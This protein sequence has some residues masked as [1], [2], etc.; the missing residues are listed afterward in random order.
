MTVF[1]PARRAHYVARWIDPETGRRK[2]H[3]LG[4]RIKREA[5]Q[6]AA[7]L[8]DKILA[9]VSPDDMAWMAFA[10]VYEAAHIAH[11]SKSHQQSW[12]AVRDSVEDLMRAPLL[13]TITAPR[14]V[15]WQERIREGRSPNTVA[16]YSTRLR[17]ALNWAR[18]RD[19]LMRTPFV[20]VRFEETPRSRGVTD[21]E[22]A[23]ILQSVPAVRP[24]DAAAWD[25]LLRGLGMTNLRISE[26]ARLSWD[27]DASIRIEQVDG[28]PMIRLAPAAH[29][30]RKPRLQVVLPEFW[31]VCRET[32]PGDRLGL[33]FPLSNGRGG[34]MT[35]KR[36]IRV[37]GSIGRAAGIVTNDAGKAATS[38]DIGKRTF[39]RRIDDKLTPVETHKTMGHAKFDTTMQF[40]ETRAAATIAAK[41]WAH[42]ESGA[43]GGAA[44]F[45]AGRAGDASSRKS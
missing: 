24:R 25:R 29:K 27:S 12:A 3:T 21:V 18:Q 38:H 41:L 14:I 39:V 1:R 16:S 8:A 13:S 5:Y 28:F 40:Y 34:N 36:I 44:D 7:E 15:K 19:Y 4:T 11:K 45:P 2:E 6:R 23:A 17:A 43:L 22:Y 30:S 20:E 31:A 35:I 10:R 9:G 32:L 26:L 42:Q 33:V 37:I